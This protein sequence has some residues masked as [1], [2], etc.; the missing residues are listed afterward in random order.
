MPRK[1]CNCGI[2]KLPQTAIR[3]STLSG[4]EIVRYPV[5]ACAQQGVERDEPRRRSVM[6]VVC[7]SGAEIFAGEPVPGRARARPEMSGHELAAGDRPPARQLVSSAMSR[8]AAV[9]WT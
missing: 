4:P 1:G 3:I 6:D 2:D 7:G 9:S 8:A 5:H